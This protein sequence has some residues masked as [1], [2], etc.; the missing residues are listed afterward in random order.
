[1]MP[2][3]MYSRRQKL[4]LR[5]A[6]AAA[7]AEYLRTLKFSADGRT[8][9]FASVYDSWPNWLQ[10]GQPSAAVLPDDK[11]VY[12]RT[13]RAPVL[14]EETWEPVGQA[15]WGLYQLAEATCDMQLLVRAAT[16]GERSAIIAEVENAFVA[17]GAS[18]NDEAGRRVGLVLPMPDYYQL[19][20]RFTLL[21]QRV[22]DD[23]ETAARNRNE[24][25]FVLAAQAPQVRLD[26]VR[27]FVGRVE[28]TVS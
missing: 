20:A 17:A 4:D 27:P 10:G 22:L 21:E 18:G 9:K 13:Q 8:F 11:L 16:N 14:M 19:D 12:P 28:Q 6:I 5:L 26:M 7:L 25:M 3:E 23:A 24:A 15:G 1:M 2:R